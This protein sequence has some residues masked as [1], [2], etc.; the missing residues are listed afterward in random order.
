MIC[1]DFESNL[2]PEDNKKQNRDEF[3]TNNCQKHVVCSY[4]YKF[5]CAD[6]KFRKSFM[7]YLG[8]DAVYNFVVF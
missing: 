6:D 3:Y 8:E 1:A 4:G 5:V 7:S 2:M